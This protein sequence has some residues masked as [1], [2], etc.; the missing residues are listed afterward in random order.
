MSSIVYFSLFAVHGT[1]HPLSS[2]PYSMSMTLS[3][4]CDWHKHN[5]PLE[6]VKS[7]KCLR[8]ECQASR[9][10]RPACDG[11]DDPTAGTQQGFSLDKTTSSTATDGIYVVVQA[12]PHGSVAH[13]P[14]SFLCLTETQSSR[15]GGDATGSTRRMPHCHLH[16]GSMHL[17]CLQV[18]ACNTTKCG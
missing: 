13:V 17:T 11:I 14:L 7:G 18:T 5:K 15:L 2:A 10:G 12:S 1:L 8:G 4:Q 6:T 9:L 3:C 16:P